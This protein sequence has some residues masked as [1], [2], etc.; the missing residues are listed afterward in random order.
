MGLRQAQAE[1]EAKALFPF[2]VSLSNQ[3]QSCETKDWLEKQGDPLRLISVLK[4]R[5]F[6][7]FHEIE[8]EAAVYTVFEV[9]N[10]RGLDV[11]W[12]DSLVKSLCRSN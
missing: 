6:F 8:D 3:R 12:F 10:S 5:L 7:L 9:L 1:R 2:V 4:N 11:T